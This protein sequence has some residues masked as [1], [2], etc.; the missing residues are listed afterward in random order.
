[1]TDVV[2]D[3]SAILAYVFDEPGG[4]MV[5]EA[6]RQ[7]TGFLISAV[8]L[9]EA[10]AKLADKGFVEEEIDSFLA[11]LDLRVV[12]LDGALARASGLLR[13]RVDRAVSLGDRCCL[14][15]G[16]ALAT[17]VMTA[18]RQWLRHADDLGLHLIVT[19]PG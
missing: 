6:A 7:G 16:M 4:D 19:R 10:Y 3:T 9:A 12:P 18:D 1:M 5:T 14:A 15:L 17:P 11:P 13:R 2:I 8:N